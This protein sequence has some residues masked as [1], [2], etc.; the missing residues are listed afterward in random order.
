MPNMVTPPGE[1]HGVGGGLRSL[2]AFL[3]TNI[4]ALAQ[5]NGCLITATFKTVKSKYEKVILLN[6]LKH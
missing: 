6:T 1:Q 4:L 2:S 3:V 5:P